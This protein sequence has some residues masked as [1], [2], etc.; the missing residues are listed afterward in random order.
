MV[1]FDVVHHLLDVVAIHRLPR[2][3]GREAH[4]VDTGR[5]RRQVEVVFI[6]DESAAFAG[7]FSAYIIEHIN[8]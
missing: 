1:L 4:G 6:V 7:N 2:R 5:D 8:I 3:A